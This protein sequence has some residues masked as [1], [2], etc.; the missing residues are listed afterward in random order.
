MAPALLRACLAG[1][2]VMFSALELALTQTVGIQS[3]DL[4]V[5]TKNMGKGNCKLLYTCHFL[6]MPF[7]IT[8]L[9]KSRA[10]TSELPLLL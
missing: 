9:F 6:K 7:P 1:V 8:A 4:P 3:T 5:S 2:D 10:G